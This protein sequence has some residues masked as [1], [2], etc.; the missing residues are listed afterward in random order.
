[1][2]D[3]T[4]RDT[5][6]KLLTLVEESIPVNKIYFNEVETPECHRL[7]FE[8]ERDPELLQTA[9]LLVQHYRERYGHSH[10]DAIQLLLAVEPFDQHDYLAETLMAEVEDG[11]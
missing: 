1:M 6:Q 7:P 9:R 4:G 2:L 5:L 3:R 10:T 8:G 11:A